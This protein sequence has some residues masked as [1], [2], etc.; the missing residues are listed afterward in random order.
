MNNNQFE[1]FEQSEQF[2]DS[3]NSPN[4]EPIICVIKQNSQ[5]Y[6]SHNITFTDG[7]FLD[8]QNNILTY[9]DIDKMIGKY[10]IG[11]N[12]V[13]IKGWDKKDREYCH[14][15][16]ESD[17]Y[18]TATGKKYAQIQTNELHRN[19]KNLNQLTD[20]APCMSKQTYK[21]YK[22]G[23]INL[24]DSILGQSSIYG[25]HEVKSENDEGIR[26]YE[27]S[28]GIISSSYHYQHSYNKAMKL[29]QTI[30]FMNMNF[31]GLSEANYMTSMIYNDLC[32]KN[33]IDSQIIY[34]SCGKIE[35]S[36]G[37]LALVITNCKNM[38]NVDNIK[39]N[40]YYTS[41]GSQNQYTRF[42][43]INFMIEEIKL[44]IVVVHLRKKDSNSIG[45]TDWVN[46]INGDVLILG[47]FNNPEPNLG[48]KFHKETCIYGHQL[49]G[50]ILI[51]PKPIDF[52]FANFDY[53]VHTPKKYIPPHE[54]NINQS[55]Y[56]EPNKK[57]EHST[58]SKYIEP[59]KKLESSTQ[60][61]YIPPNK[62][63]NAS[64]L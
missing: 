40:P 29:I 35:Q 16:N 23:C 51:F 56:I 19:L 60:P 27:L 37:T 54:R 13:F 47:D 21:N 10:S 26:I 61:K 41:Y 45:F 42:H 22:V 48:E 12:D 28:T 11:T 33:N 7:H 49:F 4:T 59:N 44:S 57:L 32:K 20:H 34:V 36:A 46:S 55:P 9:S 14:K 5:I 6:D 38:F 3:E 62:R 31:I 63:I 1:Q 24:Y 17:L 50:Y 15:Y 2:S 58:Q 25:L 52:V 64:K 18:I 8:K 53:D 43:A 39:I 30:P